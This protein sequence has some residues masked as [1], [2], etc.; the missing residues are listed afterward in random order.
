MSS[1]RIALLIV[2]GLWGQMFMLNRRLRR[3]LRRSLAAGER[4]A[5]IVRQQQQRSKA[6]EN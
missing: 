1:D 6:G 4:L 5:G 3:E 2:G